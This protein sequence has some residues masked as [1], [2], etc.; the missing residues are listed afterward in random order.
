MVASLP[1]INTGQDHIGWM[2]PDLWAGI[3]STW[4][5]PAELTIPVDIETVYTLQFLQEIYRLENA[6]H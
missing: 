4:R 3:E 1:F 2:E 6:A 5:E